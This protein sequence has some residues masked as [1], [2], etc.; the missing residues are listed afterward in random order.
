[1]AMKYAVK[2]WNQNMMDLLHS[3][4]FK[5]NNFIIN[6]TIVFKIGLLFCIKEHCNQKDQENTVENRKNKTI[7][8]YFGSST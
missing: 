5:W 4:I 8:N 6:N 2:A 1:M 7:Q 3:G